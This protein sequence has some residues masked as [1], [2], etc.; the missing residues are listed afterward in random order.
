[1]SNVLAFPTPEAS[2]FSQAWKLLP[3]TRKRRSDRKDRCE[4]LWKSESKRLGGEEA[5]LGRLRVYLRG[6]DLVRT[7]GPG[8]QIL[9]KSG[10]LEHYE[11]DPHT[12]QVRA[13]QFPNTTVRDALLARCGPD[14]VASYLDP[15]EVEG[16]VVIV[17]TDY[18]V[19]KLKEHGYAFKMAGFTGMRKRT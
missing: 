5:L 18:A 14:W 16:T 11:P 7:G 12:A 10:K 4:K 8:L 2:T 15:C 3:E 6:P 17:R 1:V 19:K 13:K 9:L